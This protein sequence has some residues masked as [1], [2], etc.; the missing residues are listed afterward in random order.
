MPLKEVIDKIQA[1]WGEDYYKL[2][3]LNPN[4]III[5][6]ANFLEI[7]KW[8]RDNEETYID[9]LACITAI[10]NGIQINTFEVVYNFQSICY[11]YNIVIKVFIERTNPTL[12]TVS[13]LWQTANWHEREIFDMFGIIFENHPDLRRILLPNDWE[14]YPLRKDYEIQEIY[15]GIQVKY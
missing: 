10:D 15:H 8:L 9:F 11:D 3:S 5:E 13:M 2:D 6:K 12:P 14:G 4:C 7:C 1:T